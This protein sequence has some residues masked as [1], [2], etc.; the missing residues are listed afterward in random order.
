VV[1]GCEE[2]W[3][4]ALACLIGAD[5]LDNSGAV[6]GRN[7]LRS[8]CNRRS[9]LHDWASIGVVQALSGG[10]GPFVRADAGAVED[11]GQHREPANFG[12]DSQRVPLCGLELFDGGAHVCDQ[13]S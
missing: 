9:E 12:E 11:S 10:E 13:F 1:G 4:G 3:K 5:C 2:F 7:S 8:C 6:E